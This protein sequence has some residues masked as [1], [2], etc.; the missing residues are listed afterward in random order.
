MD[1]NY[2]NEFKKKKTGKIIITKILDITFWYMGIQS[3]IE[4]V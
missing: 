2:I 3:D 1:F 4:K